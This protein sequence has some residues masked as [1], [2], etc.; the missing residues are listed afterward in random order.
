MLSPYL[1]GQDVMD[2]PEAL[3]NMEGNCIFIT[4]YDTIAMAAKAN[5][6]FL[7]L[8]LLL[9]LVT[10]RKSYTPAAIKASN[11]FLA[12]D[13]FI[14]ATAGDRTSFILTRSRSLTDS[15]TNIPELNAQVNIIGSNGGSFPLIDSSA[16]GIYLSAALA[17][18]NTQNY[19]LQIN[20]SDG[21]S[22]ESDF[23]PV[24]ASPP[25]DSITW[26]IVDDATTGTQALQIYVSAHDPNASTHFYRWDFLETYE[27]LSTLET[28]WGESNGLIY[29]YIA[30]ENSHTCYS[31]VHSN[32]IL[33]GSS[34]ALSQDVISQSLIA[35]LQQ[36]DPK[37]DI[38]YS[39]LVKQYPLTITGYNYWLTV[40]KNSQS[41]GGLFDLQPS[42]VT[43]NLHS[44]THPG[45]PVLGFV[46]ANTI[47]QQR[48]FINNNQ[49]PGWRSNPL[50]SCKEITVPT[51]PLNTLIYTYPDTAYGPYHFSGDFTIFLVVAPKTCLDC[52]YQGGTTTKPDFWP[53]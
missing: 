32:D 9:V 31:T 4:G 24:K 44:T 28:P 11:H 42:Q 22:Y 50:I 38:E 43:G 35:T 51:D 13:G 47:A 3:L 1:S 26:K 41:L 18:D 16:S 5:R 40:Q 37:L 12:V 46:S 20:T 52:R 10:C 14:D 49:T 33:L 48:I 34:V 53:Q 8:F 39:I 19:K 25:I 45:D 2:V 6:Y 7:L 36:N 17:L 21:N 27:H 29:P 15:V 23:A 30:P